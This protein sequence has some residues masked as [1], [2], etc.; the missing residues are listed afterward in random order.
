MLLSCCLACV[1]AATS[2][3]KL[4][5]GGMSVSVHTDG[6]Y[7]IE[8]DGSLWFDGGESTIALRAASEVVNLTQ[9]A[10]IGVTSG[11]DQWGAYKKVVLHW[12]VATSS[13]TIISTSVRA[14]IDS[15]REMLVFSQS[16]PNGGGVGQAGSDEQVIA[17]FPTFRTSSRNQTKQETLNFFQWGGCQLANSFGGRFT[18]ASSVPG[19]S[20]FGVPTL[21]YSA[22]GRGAVLSPANNWLTVTNEPG[23]HKTGVGIKASVR[24]L[25]KGFVHDTLL[26]AAP[27]INQTMQSLGDALLQKSGK[28]R[29]DSYDDFVLS[30]LGYWTDVS[31][32]EVHAPFPSRVIFLGSLAIHSIFWYIWYI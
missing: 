32:T 7:E 13:M 31:R 26:M 17:P 10:P 28:K 4:T 2:A 8:I 5:S 6:T 12:G 23:D 21:L 1:L 29:V 9:V 14:Y 20:K 18:N 16:W 27:T 15:S 24:T 11:S 3:I 30:H 25:P 19:G 22:S